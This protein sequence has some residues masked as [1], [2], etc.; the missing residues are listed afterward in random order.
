M[1]K[2]VT[3]FLP[4]GSEN[5]FDKTISELLTCPNIDQIFLLSA[6]TDI[7]IELPDRCHLYRYRQP[8]LPKNISK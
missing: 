1:N 6:Q 7:K 3:C 2:T 5:Q 4:Y 8:I